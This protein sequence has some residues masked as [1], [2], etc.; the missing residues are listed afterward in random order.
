VDGGECLI[1]SSEHQPNSSQSKRSHR[2]SE[3]P[4]CAIRASIAV[5]NQQ[6]VAELYARSGRSETLTESDYPHWPAMGAGVTDRLWSVEE[7]IELALS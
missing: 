2:L 7:L 4:D 6:Y 1:R 3:F 5:T